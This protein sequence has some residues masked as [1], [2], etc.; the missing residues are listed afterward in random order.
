[1]HGRS[2][3]P[4][5]PAQTDPARP[6]P[7][8]F[9]S[10][11]EQAARL[12]PGGLPR[13]TRTHTFAARLTRAERDDVQC[14]LLRAGANITANLT[15]GRQFC[16]LQQTSQRR[17]PVLQ[18]IFSCATFHA[19]S[20]TEYFGRGLARAALLSRP[21][22]GPT[23]PREYSPAPRPASP[24]STSAPASRFGRRRA[25]MIYHPAL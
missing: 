25:G 4:A 17:T 21:R 16:S 8:R 3:A 5:T 13:H 7:R 9:R 11:G 18:I 22:E 12:W 23:T 20:A 24:H 10:T 14:H 2:P 1:M 6:G 15:C 19:I